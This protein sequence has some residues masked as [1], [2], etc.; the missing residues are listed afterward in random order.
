MGYPQDHTIVSERNSHYDGVDAILPVREQSDTI[1]ELVRGH[2]ESVLP[3]AMRESSLDMWIILCREDHLDPVFTTMIPM[4]CWCPILQMLIFVDEGGGRIRRYNVSGTDT[5]DLYE[6]PY[7]GQVEEEQWS[8]LAD[9][10]RKR[11]PKNIGVNIGE[12]KWAAG[13]LSLPLYLKLKSVIG[14]TYAEW[15]VSAEKAVIR[16]SATLTNREI[17]YYRQVIAIA[18]DLIAGCYNSDTISPG[19]TTVDDLVWHYWQRAVDAGLELAFRPYFRILR[20]AGDSRY[21]NVKDGVI[22]PGDVIHCDV[23]IRYLR[24]NSDNQQLAY[25]VKPGETDVPMYLRDLMATTNELQS[26]FMSEFKR[27]ITGNELLRN[28]L[29]RAREEGIPSPMV[30]SHSIGLFLHQ[31]GPLI[32]LPWA[33]DGPLPRGETPLEYNY[34]FTMELSTEDTVNEWGGQSIRCPLE[35]P[36]VFTQDGCRPL[37]GRQTAYYLV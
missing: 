33:Q 2:L 31:P 5:K 29:K 1:T 26:I 34:A 25:V 21:E 32:G 19:V 18:H 4:D 6:R 36:V 9:I 10:V 15:L 7:S 16:W 11:D 8:V 30:Y 17:G 12:V 24:L 3:L 22:R 23:G 20:N 14:D 27:G 13:G 28:I 37:Y 35:E